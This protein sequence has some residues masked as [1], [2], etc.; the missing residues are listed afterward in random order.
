MKKSG[1]FAILFAMAMVAGCNK[2]GGQAP[3]EADRG[4]VVAKVNGADI[5]QGQVSAVL[6][7]LGNIPAEQTAVA[8]KQVLEK[9]VEEHLVLQQAQEKKLDQDPKVAQALNAARNEVL[10][11]AY[12]EQIAT[13]AGKPTETDIQAFYDKNPALFKERKVYNLRELSVM[14]KPDLAPRLE[15]AVKKAKNLEEVANW[16]KSEKVGFSVSAAPKAAEQLPLELVA[17]FA[18]M[19]D[20]ETVIL[21]TPN[22]LLVVQVVASQV[23]PVDLATAKPAIERLMSSQKRNDAAVR[24]V[25]QL[26]EKA[27]VEYFGQYAESK[28]AAVPEKK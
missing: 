12:L 1:M 15:E 19:K 8:G 28:P 23:Q 24:E 22:A 2:G 16:L 14:A 21:P 20:G 13:A 27:K 6:S 25:K 7:R 11:K 4:P 10:M 3:S 18:L 17:K 5:Y 9:I 26:R